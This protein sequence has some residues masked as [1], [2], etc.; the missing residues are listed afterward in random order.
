MFTLVSVSLL[1]QLWEVFLKCFFKLKSCYLSNCHCFF[2]FITRLNFHLKCQKIFC[3]QFVLIHKA[4]FFFWFFFQVISP[5]YFMQIGTIILRA[6][7]YLFSFWQTSMWPF[8]F[9]CM[10]L[11]NHGAV[12]CSEVERLNTVLELQQY[13]LQH[14][15]T[16]GTH[17]FLNNFHI[18]NGFS[19]FVFLFFLHWLYTDYKGN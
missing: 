2:F 18:V 19:F 6:N 7:I 11:H 14:T 1:N 3:C 17:N 12:W 9:E 8:S 10:V 4:L 16:G 5:G 13:P 15:H